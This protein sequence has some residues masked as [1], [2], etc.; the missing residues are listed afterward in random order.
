MPLYTVTPATIQMQCQHGKSSLETDTGTYGQPYKTTA[1]KATI[2][3]AVIS[4]LIP[5]WIVFILKQMYTE[6]YYTG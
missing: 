3:E 1:N 4:Q 2:K 6:Q 5:N